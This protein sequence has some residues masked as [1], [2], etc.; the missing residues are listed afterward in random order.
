MIKV[1]IIGAGLASLSAMQTLLSSNNN[2]QVSIFEKARGPGGRLASR[3]TPYGAIDIGAQYFT[4]RSPAFKAFVNQL[5]KLELV[6]PWPITPWKITENETKASPDNMQRFVGTPRM[7]AISRASIDH[8]AELHTSTRIVKTHYHN[9]QWFLYAENNEDAPYGPFDSVIVTTPP[10]QAIDLLANTRLETVCRQHTMLAC[11]ATWIAFDETFKSP[12]SAAFCDHSIFDWIC[13]MNSKPGRAL[14]KNVWLVTTNPQWS[15]HNVDM[16][17]QQV[18]SLVYKE[19]KKVFAKINITLPNTPLDSGSHRWLY[20][21][22]KAS[23]QPFHEDQIWDAS[24]CIGLA[25]D[26]CYEGRVEGSFLAGHSA[27]QQVL[28]QLC[29]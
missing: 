22:P 12:F 7:N 1:A 24:K 17:P 16:P 4:A 15:E 10:A 23:A 27:A 13:H 11:W 20:A 6:Q 5:I 3:R 19:F 25:G 26:W 29:P 21:R 8:R 14:S 28:R 9:K 2:V 18:E